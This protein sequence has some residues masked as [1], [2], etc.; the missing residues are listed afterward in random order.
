MSLD[1]RPKPDPQ[2]PRRVEHQFA[3]AP[4]YSGVQHYC[5]CLHVGQFAAE[6][7]VFESCVRGLREEGGGV[8]G[9]GR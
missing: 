2:L 6:E 4:D 3:V 9:W 7:V 1:M 5:R 8:V